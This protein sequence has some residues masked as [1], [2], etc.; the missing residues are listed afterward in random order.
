MKT[1]VL[2]FSQKGYSPLFRYPISIIH[3]DWLPS[4]EFRE[5]KNHVQKLLPHEIAESEGTHSSITESLPEERVYGNRS[6]ELQE[7]QELQEFNERQELQDE[8][9][10]TTS[11]RRSNTCSQDPGSTHVSRP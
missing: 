9:T 8:Q 5:M 2:R 4:E 1:M 7:L 11:L 6:L 10:K 3:N